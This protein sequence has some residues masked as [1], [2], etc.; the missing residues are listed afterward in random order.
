MEGNNYESIHLTKHKSDE[1][2]DIK[3]IINS[4]QDIINTIINPIIF[5]LVRILM[6][7][8]YPKTPSKDNNGIVIE[9]KLNGK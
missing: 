5:N 7:E 2:F 6:G 1:L 3:I 8:N 4:F 9:K